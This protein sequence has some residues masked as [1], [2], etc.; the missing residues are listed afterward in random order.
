MLNDGTKNGFMLTTSI[1]YGH[2]RYEDRIEL[3]RIQKNHFFGNA[4]VD[5]YLDSENSEKKIRPGE[6][7]ILIST[8]PKY[9]KSYL[10]DQGYVG[11]D[12]F[13]NTLGLLR[14][15]KDKKHYYFYWMVNESL[16]IDNFKKKYTR[17]YNSR[18]EMIRKLLKN[19]SRI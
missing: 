2:F 9:I 19:E 10:N 7:R 18:Y 13:E 17:N 14:T 4:Y 5:A 12:S 16:E 11:Y 6:C 15:Y 1:A 8:L 3:D